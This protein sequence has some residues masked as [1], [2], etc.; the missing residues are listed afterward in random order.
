MT[1]GQ[2]EYCWEQLHLTFDCA[3]NFDINM[4]VQCTRRMTSITKLEGDK[5]R[6][7]HSIHNWYY[8]Y[9]SEKMLN[10]LKKRAQPFA[11]ELD[12]SWTHKSYL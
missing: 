7:H 5:W 9:Q 11:T 1:F 2:T 12:E 10:I 8:A 3:V 6:P 4:F